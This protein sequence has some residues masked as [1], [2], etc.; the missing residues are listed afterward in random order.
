MEPIYLY[1]DIKEGYHVV[2]FGDSNELLST[3]NGTVIQSKNAQLIEN[4]V[5]DLQKYSEVS[6]QEN[7]SIAGAPLEDI[8]LYSL[9]CT[10]ID[11][12]SD[13]NKTIELDEMIQSLAIDPIA[14]IAP[15]PEQVDQIH[16][17]R[18]VIKLLEENHIKFHNIQYFI[19][20][21]SEME[22]LAK[23]VKEDFDKFTN[24]QRAAFI[25][26]NYLLALLF[27][28]GHSSAGVYLKTH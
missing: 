3:P 2:T 20:D 7:N 17:W 9:V 12:W 26:L 1:P 5:F 11:F 10:E 25:Q 24:S 19:E 18:S 21:R 13:Q 22:K 16:Q 8:S 6:P 15:G 28:F 23:L 27:V 14:N 4:L